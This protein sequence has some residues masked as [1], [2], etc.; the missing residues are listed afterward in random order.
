M[1]IFKNV[2]IIAKAID[3]KK[4][5]EL[6]VLDLRGITEIADYFVIATGNNKAH[7]NSLSENIEDSLEKQ[8]PPVFAIRKHGHDKGEWVILD[9][10]DIVVHLFRGETRKFYDLDKFWRSAKIVEVE[11]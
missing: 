5:E 4:G 10:G 3:D 8:E 7:I 1:D 6:R 11:V 2:E 9:Y